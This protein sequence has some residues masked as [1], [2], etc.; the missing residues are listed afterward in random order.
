MGVAQ[1]VEHGRTTTALVSWA[2]MGMFL[3]VFPLAPAPL[4]FLSLG[5]ML[6]DSRLIPRLFGYAA[7][8]IGDGF[9]VLG[10]IGFANPPLAGRTIVLVE[11]QGLWTLSAGIA[12]ITTT[13]TPRAAPR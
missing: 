5:V 8:I 4:V 1:A 9:L 12:L 11:L 3:R 7:L 2:L 13:P 6:L 10:E